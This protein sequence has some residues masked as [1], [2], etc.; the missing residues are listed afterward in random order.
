MIPKL[1]RFLVQTIWAGADWATE[2]FVS[3]CEFLIRTTIQAVIA[4]IIADILIT[5]SIRFNSNLLLILGITIGGGGLLYFAVVS[6]PARMAAEW[7]SHLSTIAEQEIERLSNIFFLL[8]V[9]IF[10]LGVDQG[11]QHPT[12][13]KV[14][15]GMMLL[16]FFVAILPGQSKTIMF[17]KRR[18]QM[19]VFIPVILMTIFAVTP[20]A[21]A[22]RIIYSHG[23]EKATGTIATEISYRLN[24]DQEQIIDGANG[25]PMVF[26]DQ[27]AAKNSGQPRPLIGWT[28]DKKNQYHLYRW[29]DGQTNYNGI[30]Q[31]IK[32]ITTDKLDDIIAQAKREA[33]EKAANDAETAIKKA[34]EEIA[35]ALA[36]ANKQATADGEAPQNAV[37][38][39]E[40][41]KQQEEKES[42]PPMNQTNELARSEPVE[43]A[44]SEPAESETPPNEEIPNEAVQ[45]NPPQPTIQLIP[46]TVTI[47]PP[48]NKFADKDLIAVRPNTQFIYQGKTIRPYQSV[49]TLRIIDV[50]STSEKDQYLITAHPQ[51]LIV[52]STFNNQT[53]DIYS[54][55]ES[56]QFLAKKDDSHSLAKIITGTAIGAG[57]GA[58]IDGK[59]GAARGAIIGGGAGAVYAIASH[60]KTF[61]IP[62]S[63][64]LPPVMFRP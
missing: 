32:P 58:L 11:Q 6:S 44:R 9:I 2:V 53:Y 46:V 57:I 29:F 12:L 18:F 16:L 64:T 62:I 28:Q 3:Y 7:L 22:N 60:G 56:L 13:L 41:I 40:E 31:E 14:F 42:Q 61:Q 39:E 43:S 54:Q 33:E 8:M 50:T 48:N 49:I 21:I 51:S 4:V 5:T 34:H 25:Q 23:L 24:N 17:F 38:E 52:N 1:V 26:F 47:L 63:D 35:N 19:L 45:E 30:G 59:K 37:A 10:Y 27:I 20:E 15:L 36:L 55:T